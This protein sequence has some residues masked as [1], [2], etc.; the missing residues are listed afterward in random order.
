M[1]ACGRTILRTYRTLCPPLSLFHSSFDRI[2]H[3]PKARSLLSPSPSGSGAFAYLPAPLHVGT[4][5]PAYVGKDGD[6]TEDEPSSVSLASLASL[7]S[8]SSLPPPPNAGDDESYAIEWHAKRRAAI[9]A[10]HPELTELQN[11]HNLMTPVIGLAASA[12]HAVVCVVLMDLPWYW[13]LILAYTVG[14]FWYVA[15]GAFGIAFAPRFLPLYLP[16]ALRT[17]R[18]RDTRHPLSFLVSDISYSRSY[19]S[20]TVHSTI[21]PPYHSSAQLPH[22]SYR[23]PHSLALP[24]TPLPPPPSHTHPI[25]LN[26]HPT[27]AAR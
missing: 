16:C 10:A 11:T 19:H 2:G 24:F 23:S 25:P 9:L 12:V 17:L 22:V 18:L 26:A 5:D 14:A 13:T 1:R 15:G 8:L 21:H 7:A 3:S 27:F 4:L 6:P 20:S